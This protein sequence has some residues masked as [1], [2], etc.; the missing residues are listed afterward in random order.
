MYLTM[1]MY[2]L[3]F[4]SSITS[5]GILKTFLEVVRIIIIHFLIVLKQINFAQKYKIA[6]EVI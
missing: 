3:N 5:L 4:T 1:A 2:F 6:N